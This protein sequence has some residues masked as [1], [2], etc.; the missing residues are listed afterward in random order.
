MLLSVDND[1]HFVVSIGGLSDA[2]CF[3]INGKPGDTFQLIYDK[4]TG[5]ENHPLNF[6]LLK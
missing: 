1:P 2:V 4:I 6:I 5:M 3:D